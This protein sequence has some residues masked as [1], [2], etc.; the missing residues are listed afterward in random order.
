MGYKTVPKLQQ[1]T[2]VAADDARDKMI[3]EGLNGAFGR[4]GLVQVGGG[5]S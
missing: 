5:T 4:V 2:R 3:F 1:K